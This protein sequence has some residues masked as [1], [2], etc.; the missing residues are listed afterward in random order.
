MAPI[1]KKNRGACDRGRGRVRAAAVELRGM[2]PPEKPVQAMSEVEH[3]AT[4][5]SVVLEEMY[6]KAM[7]QDK[8]GDD[9]D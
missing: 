9:E 6:S 4:H 7:R 2:R 3:R 1:S 5:V 8:W